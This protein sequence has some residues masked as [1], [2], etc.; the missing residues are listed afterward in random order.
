MKDI[1]PD[2]TPDSDIPA[3]FTYLGQFIDHDITLEAASGNV[4]GGL[5]N[6]RLAPLSVDEVRSGLKNIRTAALDLDSVYGTPDKSG[7]YSPA[8]RDA[9][10]PNKMRLGDVTLLQGRQKPLLR[11]KGKD[12]KN[13]L[14]REGRSEDAA[15]DRAALIGD[16]RNDENLIIAQLHTAFLRAHNALVAQEG[17]TFDQAQKALRQHYQWLVLH[18]F[19]EIM[20]GADLVEDILTNGPKHYPRQKGERFFLPFEFTVAAYRFGHTMIRHVYDHNVNF[21]DATLLQLFTFTALSGNLSPLPGAADPGGLDTLPDNWIIEWDHFV[22][23]GDG[24]PANMARRLDTQITEPLFTLRDLDGNPLRIEPRLAARNLLRGYLLRMPT[25]QA[26]AGAMGVTPLK[27]EDLLA[28]AATVT[29]RQ[30]KDSQADVLKSAGF[31]ER[32]PLWYYILAEAA[33]HGA[34]QR[35]GPVGGRLVAEVLIELIRRGKDSIL[36]TQG[37]KPTL[38]SGNGDF[39]LTD[40][41]RLANVL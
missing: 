38:G 11:P 39:T 16:P 18:D 2:A 40:L 33:H 14:P 5:N 13:D 4:R 22:D 37:W 21:P 10:D 9:N 19:L 30:G 15:T 28:V 31:L 41:L 17:M 6:P 29:P 26:V 1:E 12:D 36:A 32:T 7:D 35:L 23:T 8:L 25:G 27:P 24:R 20:V 3:A 34:G